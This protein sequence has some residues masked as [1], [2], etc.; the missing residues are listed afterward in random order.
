MACGIVFRTRSELAQIPNAMYVKCL[1][2]NGNKLYK[3]ESHSPNLKAH[4]LGSQGRER[5]EKVRSRE[6]F[7]KNNH[8]L[9]YIYTTKS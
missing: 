3:L 8:E 7:D 4:G 1:N 6:G 2:N 9:G 5:K